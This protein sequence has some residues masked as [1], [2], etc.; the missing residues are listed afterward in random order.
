MSLSCAF[1]SDVVAVMPNLV[2]YLSHPHSSLAG[3]HRA[4]QGSVC[5]NLDLP[6]LDGTGPKGA[7]QERRGADRR[8]GAYHPLYRQE[9]ERERPTR[10]SRASHPAVTALDAC[11]A[12]CAAIGGLGEPEAPQPPGA[13]TAKLDGFGRSCCAR[14]VAGPIPVVIRAGVGSRERVA[15]LLS[16]RALA[17]R[18]RLLRHV[19]HARRVD[20][21][22]AIL[23][24][25]ARNG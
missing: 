23:T 22:E 13:N 2:L 7:A 14:G 6:L 24:T 3:P 20:V 15:H 21:G 10:S 25:A 16:V 11:G 5:L 1:R 8:F 9:G 17:G 12:V 4:R 19:F 18:V